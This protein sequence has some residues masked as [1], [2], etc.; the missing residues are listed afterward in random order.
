MIGTGTGQI[1]IECP[2]TIFHL[3]INNEK[4][5]TKIETFMNNIKAVKSLGIDDIYNW[6]NRQGILYDTKFNYHKDFSLWTNI[7]YYF[8]YS[9]QKMR[10]QVLLGAV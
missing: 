3:Y 2:N 6:C 8:L 9:S 10:Y 7:R 1:L 4:E 5:Y